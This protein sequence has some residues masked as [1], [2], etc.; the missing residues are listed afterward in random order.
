MRGRRPRTLARQEST[1]GAIRM[2]VWC[3]V[4][5]RVLW[6]VRSTG[7]AIDLGALRPQHGTAVGFLALLPRVVSDICFP[8][9]QKRY[10]L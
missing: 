7:G 6:R 5:A 3:V 10:R 8:F 4:G 9:T 2:G 1:G